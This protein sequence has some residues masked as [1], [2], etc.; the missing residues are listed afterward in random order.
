MGDKTVIN[1][2]NL[3]DP[4]TA[5]GAAKVS[6]DALKGAFGMVLNMCQAMANAPVVV[7]APMGF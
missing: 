2:L 3:V 1:R 7:G 5:T 6:L 4:T